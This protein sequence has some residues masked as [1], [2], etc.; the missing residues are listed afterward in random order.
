MSLK[1]ALEE[2]TGAYCEEAPKDA[3]YPYTVFSVRR[4]SDN[5]GGQS[6]ILEVNAWD[7]HAY[8]SR[9]ESVMDEL[10]KKLHWC[11]H[12]TDE[13][14]IRIFKGRRQNVPDPDK[15]MKRVMEQ[16]EMHVFER[17]E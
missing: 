16:F 3:V 2:L 12:L 10:E 9:A 13:F 7:Q 5:E 6:Y 11:N 1:K 17:E 15:T 14:L 8:Y 4:L